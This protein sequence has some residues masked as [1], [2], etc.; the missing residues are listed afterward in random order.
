[1]INYPCGWFD[2]SNSPV[3]LAPSQKTDMSFEKGLAELERIV[4]KLESS[5]LAQSLRLLS[6]DLSQMIQAWQ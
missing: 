2:A 5:C 3:V 1:M 4:A 6:Q